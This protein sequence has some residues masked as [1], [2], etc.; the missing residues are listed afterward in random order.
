MKKYFA[1]VALA[2]MGL[3]LAG[4]GTSGTVDDNFGYNRPDYK[5]E[6]VRTEKKVV[7]VNKNTSEENWE[8]PLAGDNTGNDD[9]NNISWVS[10]SQNVVYVP[11]IVPWWYDYYGWMSYPSYR[12]RHSGIYIGFGYDYWNDWYSPYYDWY[13]PWYSYDPYWGNN[14]HYRPHWG[15][16][17]WYYHDNYYHNHHGYSYEPDRVK[18][19]TDRNFGVRRS[20]VN[21]ANSSESSYTNI[22]ASRMTGNSRTGSGNDKSIYQDRNVPTYDYSGSRS[23]NKNNVGNPTD[24]RGT[25]KSVYDNNGTTGSRKYVSPDYTPSGSRTNTDAD[26]TT[27][28]SSEDSYKSSGS[29]SRSSTGSSGSTYK[30]D[31]SSTSK[32]SGTSS[33][34]SSSRTTTSSP[35]SSSTKSSGSSSS[36]S[37]SGS[38][39]SSGSSGSSGSSSSRSSGGR[40]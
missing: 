11:V 18:N 38:S 1:S 33:S 17:D 26:R 27:R 5:V 15:Y 37:S 28:G 34:S 21:N 20:G 23:T 25:S 40:R 30:P 8:N 35:S 29:S 16:H 2:I 10:S 39:R 22:G 24:S 31:N 13:S 4:C 12:Y 6:P 19:R 32:S 3:Y 9:N 7:V 36:S 14:W